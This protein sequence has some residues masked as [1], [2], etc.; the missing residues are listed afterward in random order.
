MEKDSEVQEALKFMR[1]YIST[2]KKK[3]TYTQFAFARHR[4]LLFVSHLFFLGCRGTTPTKTTQTIRH[5]VPSSLQPAGVA[6]G[7]LFS[8]EVRQIVRII[9]KPVTFPDRGT[10]ISSARVA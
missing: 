10:G 3:G 6:Y 5:V 7:L 8:K 2:V 4:C 9:D 1:T